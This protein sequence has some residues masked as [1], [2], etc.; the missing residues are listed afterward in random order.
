[1]AVRNN[2]VDAM[3]V[4]NYFIENVCKLREVHAAQGCD[5]DVARIMNDLCVMKVHKC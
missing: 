1:M 5:D 2:D 3:P 4:V